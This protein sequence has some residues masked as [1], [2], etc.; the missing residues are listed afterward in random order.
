MLI[1]SDEND[2]W[3]IVGMFE[4]EVVKR[5]LNLL[6]SMQHSATDWFEKLI[7][8]EKYFSK[9]AAMSASQFFPERKS[10]F[11]NSNFYKVL[12]SDIRFQR[13]K[14]RKSCFQGL[15]VEKYFYFDFQQL[16]S[17]CLVLASQTQH[18]SVS[19]SVD[20]GLSGNTAD[21]IIGRN[22]LDKVFLINTFLWP[23]NEREKFNKCLFS[24]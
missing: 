7:S 21:N 5:K 3:E 11:T 9:S 1:I 15:F 6:V 23:M 13:R 8:E 22:I 17:S 12:S 19:W 24:L 14:S 20:R 10:N 16:E 4:T 2:V 18:P